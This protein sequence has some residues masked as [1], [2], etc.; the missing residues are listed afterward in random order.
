VFRESFKVAHWR[1]TLFWIAIRCTTWSPA[2]A[3]WVTSQDVQNIHVR[4]VKKLNWLANSPF[5]LIKSYQAFWIDI[6]KRF[7]L[8]FFSKPKSFNWNAE[9]YAK[10]KDW[11]P[12]KFSQYYVSLAVKRLRKKVLKPH[13]PFSPGKCDLR[14]LKVWLLWINN[15]SEQR[16]YTLKVSTER[17]LTRAGDTIFV[18]S[19]YC[20]LYEYTW[21]PQR[22]KLRFSMDVMDVVLD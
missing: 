10:A 19:P 21:K 22:R 8:F 12:V 6:L 2:I 16:W 7:L 4:F 20:F 9:F 13:R 1:N 18:P 5:L 15:R 14:G 3:C 17:C 11:F